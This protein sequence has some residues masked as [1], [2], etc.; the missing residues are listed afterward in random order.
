MGNSVPT[1]RLLRD[2]H[3][4]GDAGAREQLVEMYLPLVT[5]LA[6]RYARAGADYDDLVQ[7]GSI[8]LIKAIDRFDLSRGDELAAYAVPNISG[9]IKRH[10]RDNGETIRLPRAMQDDPEEKARVLTAGQVE[11]V[12][13]AGDGFADAEGRL[14]LADAFGGL[15]ER[16]RQILYLRFVRDLDADQVA[17]EL[18]I[19]RRHLSRQTQVALAQLR[20]ELE[21]D[22]P[23][24]S[25]RP[26]IAP[27]TQYVDRPYHIV[28]VR[29]ADDASA[30]WIAQVEE[31]PGCEARAQTADEATHAI[32]ESMEAWIS[33]ALAKHQEIP[34][35]RAAST[36]SGRLN[37]RM[38]QSLH[39]AVARAA[40]RDDV[41]L[42][43]FITG[44][45]AGAVAWRQENH[46][47]EPEVTEAEPD[48]PSRSRTA[49]AWL[50]RAL[51]A[52]AVLL[53]VAGIAAIALLVVVLSQS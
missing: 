1:A 6:R 12:P 43:Q 15:G 29:E 28:L 11:G 39:A 8:G 47:Q 14:A 41:S 26:K 32:R 9:E 17:Q 34:E 52:N 46:G 33:E 18:G 20:R 50:G 19:S 36:H 38:P 13:D 44:S 35:P 25:D 23:A 30:A 5:A 27:V 51:V 16:E 22:L 24:E 49:S 7:V 2:Y 53:A 48:R 3:L 40:E 37:L 10:L 21:R 4:N 42:N 31:L 45:L